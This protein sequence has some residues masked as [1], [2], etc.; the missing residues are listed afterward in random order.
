MSPEV[1]Y[2]S[3][4]SSE[5]EDDFEDANDEFFTAQVNSP[6][7]RQHIVGDLEDEDEDDP[8]L[9]VK[10]DHTERK[11]GTLPINRDGSLDYDGEMRRRGF[12]IAQG[13]YHLCFQP[14]TTM[15]LTRTRCQWSP[16]DRW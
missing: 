3:Y 14:C 8:V 11:G 7:S 4:S 16:M 13:I 12:N 5:G 9:S 6:M 1:P 15:I 10:S 2:T